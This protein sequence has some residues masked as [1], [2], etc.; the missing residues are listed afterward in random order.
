M[1]AVYALRR[2]REE[3]LQELDQQLNACRQITGKKL[4][5][6]RD[7]LVQKEIFSLE[8]VS[9]EISLGFREYVRQ[10]MLLTPTQKESYEPALETVL[11]DFYEKENRA[12]FDALESGEPSTSAIR[13]AEMYLV[14]H[15]IKSAEEITYDVREAY[16]QYLS[17]S[18]APSKVREYV[19]ALDNMKL[20]AIRKKCEHPLRDQRLKYDGGKVF[21]SYHPDYKIA[22]TFYYVQ[23]KDE[24]LFD[25]SLQGSEL[26]KRQVF[27]MLNHVLETQHD[28]KSRRERFLV[29]L[30]LLYLFCLEQQIEDIEQLEK[31]SI[32]LFYERLEGLEVDKADDYYQIVDNI[33]KFLFFQAKKINWEAN[34]WYLERMHILDGRMN[35]A[36]PTASFTFYCVEDKE[37]RRVFQ[38]Y[39]KYLI[40]ISKLSINSIRAR[41]YAIRQFLEYCDK[42]R[43]SV[44][45]A[46]PEDMDRYFKWVDKDIQEATFNDKLDGIAG[47]FQYMVIKGTREEIPFIKAYYVKHE[48]IA[49][50]DRAVPQETISAIL[51]NL[52][53]FPEP[54]RLIYLHLWCL[55]LRISEVCA[56]KGRAYFMQNGDAWIKVY[57][58][59]MR[60]EKVIPIPSM[61][62][63]AMQSW[64]EKNKIAADSYVFQN[65]TGGA[66]RETTFRDQ[67]IRMCRKLGINCGDYVFR[68]HD[69]RHTVSTTMYQK[70]ISVPAIR[71]YLGH[72]SE[73]MT[74]QYIDYLPR[75]IDAAN[76]QYFQKESNWLA[77]NE[78]EKEDVTFEN[79]FL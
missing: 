47:L 49:H 20:E 58:N 65:T 67:M 55:G 61:L 22:K 39:M 26:I 54:V 42:Q 28:W 72:Q 43:L 75:K 60:A 69:Y 63:K 11:F 68:A 30:K 6:V 33:R 59:K 40:G 53:Q 32:R 12:F 71:D 37:N 21:L 45:T 66:Y 4:D 77:P 41:Y 15:G 17:K 38:Q 27:S 44:Q 57:Q 25:F 2:R 29:P 34:V 7:Y 3:Y 79:L 31:S 56:L 78:E 62:Y 64:I 50:H 10:Q 23:D 8:D 14:M 16:Q 36:N 24:L 73:D 74:K 9:D 1:S 35:P 70:N 76:R 52:Y 13:K 46:T 5:V 19:K 18:I 48:V 51:S